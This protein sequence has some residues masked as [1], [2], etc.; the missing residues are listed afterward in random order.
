[1]STLSAVLWI[2]GIALGI[3][4]LCAII[5]DVEKNKENKNFDE[6][7]QAKRNAGYRV[8]FYV[9]FVYYGY[10]MVGFVGVRDWDAFQVEP[11]LLM[12][13]GILLQMGTLHAYALLT[14]SALPLGE[15]PLA[16][17]WGYTLAGVVWLINA[18][19]YA[20]RYPGSGMP[21]RG[22]DS[23]KWVPLTTG[24]FFLLLALAHLISML[25]KRK[26]EE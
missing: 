21:L 1:M 26:E 19:Q 9:G 4:V 7:Q 22:D 14:D 10:I 17:V 20:K 16:M 5:I 24:I 13:F 12:Y 18:R 6:R 2:L 11:Y 15:K 23:Y 3:V 25:R 8:A